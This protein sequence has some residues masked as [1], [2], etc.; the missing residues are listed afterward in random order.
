MKPCTKVGV[1]VTWRCQAKCRHCFYR[2]HPKMRTDTDVPIAEIEGKIFAA[3]V[4]GLDHVVMVGYGEPALCVCTPRVIKY[5]KQCGMASSMITNGLAEPGSYH[6]FFDFGLDHLHISSHGLHTVCDGIMG[7]KGAF[8]QQTRLKEALQIWNKPFRTNATLQDQNYRQLPDLADHEVEM[9]VAH[10]VFLG[11]LPHYTTHDCAE[12]AVHP[13]T[14]RPYIEEAAQRLIEAETLF[15]I[16]YHPLCQ[17][18]PR[19]WP[20][21]TNANHVL[22]DPWEWNHTL[23]VEDR[24]AL[25]RAAEELGASTANTTPCDRCAMHDH[26]GGWN[27]TYADA[28]D[29]AGLQAIP[30]VPLMWVDMLKKTTLHDLNPAN[31]HSGTFGS[32]S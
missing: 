18:D 27:R 11:F 12:I 6:R 20:Y 26:C 29:G 7:V 23:Q 8:A 25:N 4:G 1:E 31:L 2:E 15:T 30:E 10:F 3:K 13:A 5:A 16:R 21:V 17:L 24:E 19:Y 22:F 28:F 9:G 14:L 32:L